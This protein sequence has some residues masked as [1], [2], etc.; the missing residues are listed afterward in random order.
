MRPGSAFDIAPARGLR[1]MRKSMVL[2]LVG[3]LVATATCAET[4]E[5]RYGAVATAPA[6]TG[7]SWIVSLD[8]RE[9][10]VIEAESVSLSRV[11]PNGPLDDIIIEKWLPGLH[12]HHEYLVLTILPD[13]RTRLSPSFGECMELQGAVALV[14]GV[15]V[16]LRSPASPGVKQREALYL[17]S[18]GELS[19]Q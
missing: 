16:R 1:A 7:D 15:R 5:S 8:G 4:L 10:A 12:C 18:N 19:R 6:K 2:G 9:V 17:W 13:G 11:T 3:L 14:Q